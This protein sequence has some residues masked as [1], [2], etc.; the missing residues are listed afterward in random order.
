MQLDDLKLEIGKPYNIDYVIKE[1]G[2]YPDVQL[3]HIVIVMTNE[4]KY[5]QK[6]PQLEEIAKKIKAAIA[7]GGKEYEKVGK[8]FI[9]LTD[10]IILSLT[11]PYTKYEKYGKFYQ[12]FENYIVSGIEESKSGSVAAATDIIINEARKIGTVIEKEEEFLVGMEIFFKRRGIVTSLAS[13]GKYVIFEKESRIPSRVTTTISDVETAQ[14][15]YEKEHDKYSAYT[16]FY[17]SFFEHI[18][19]YMEESKK[20]DIAATISSIIEESQRTGYLT[21]GKEKDFLRGM[22]LY[23]KIKGLRVEKMKTDDR[24]LVFRKNA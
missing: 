7:K 24:Y 1:L 9:P 14:R 4:H 13:G 17:D 12:S 16:G 6:K 22:E 3:G 11:D 15:E 5:H 20:E 21:I 23:F 18:T 2:K 8:K 19:Q 10:I